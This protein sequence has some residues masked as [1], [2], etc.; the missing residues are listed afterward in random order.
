MVANPDRTSERSLAKLRVLCKDS[1]YY[2]V[3]GYLEYAL[4]FHIA[5]D[6]TLGELFGD[7]EEVV[8]AASEEAVEAE[9]RSN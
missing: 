2:K 8:S 3:E 5:P 4:A 6:Q 9:F 1:T 7:Q